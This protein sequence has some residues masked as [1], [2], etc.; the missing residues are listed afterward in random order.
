[1]VESKQKNRRSLNA[2]FSEYRLKKLVLCFAQDLTVKETV[3]T[4]KMSEPTVRA[5]F[6][7]IRQRIYDHG[8]MRVN[9]RSENK[10]PARII[11][12]KKH[13]GVPEKYAHL[14]EVEFLH[15]VLTSRNTKT[16]HKFDAGND[17]E[18]AKVRK[19]INYNKLEDKYNIVELL[20]VDAKGAGTTQRPFDPMDF[21]RSST[22]LINERKVDPHDSFFRFIWALLLKHP[23]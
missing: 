18:L 17:A 23:L 13:R 2:K 16:V 22:I 19:F 15:R 4:T 10:M 9:R 21:E 14:Y 20:K 8:F 12:Q 11:F 7:M 6:M 3:A 5:H 1:V